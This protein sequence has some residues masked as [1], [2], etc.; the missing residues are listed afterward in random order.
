M[1]LA[2]IEACDVLDGVE[3]GII[4]YPGLCDFDA[5]SAVGK[6]YVCAATGENTTITSA[7]AKVANA[8]WTGP[9]DA[10]GKSLWYG[11]AP[12]AT[13]DALVNISCTDDVCRGNPFTIPVEW[14]SVFLARD[15]DFDLTTAVNRTSIA[16]LMRQSANIYGSIIGTTDADLTDFRDAG[17]KLLSWH[18][19]ADQLI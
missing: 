6:E 12:G 8:T 14:I 7:A 15:L 16:R 9:V 5:S 4:S 19:L 1:R 11:L 18:G 3:D 2:A 10:D 13:F 17:G